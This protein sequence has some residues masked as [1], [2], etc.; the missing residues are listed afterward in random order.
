[1]NDYAEEIKIAHVRGIKTVRGHGFDVR[2]AP[3]EGIYH[4]EIHYTSPEAVPLLRSDKGELKLA[5]QKVFGELVRCPD[6]DPPSS[7]G[8]TSTPL[9]A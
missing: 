5:L 7:T 1:M 6:P 4:A 2:H 9:D 8:V 3:S